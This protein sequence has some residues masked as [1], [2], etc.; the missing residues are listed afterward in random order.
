MPQTAP[1]LALAVAMVRTVASWQAFL[2]TVLNVTWAA[3]MPLHGQFHL[4]DM[5]SIGDSLPLQ[6]AGGMLAT[7][8]R[9]KY[10][11]IL[12]GAIAGSAPIWSYLGEVRLT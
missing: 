7:W 12:D 8:M 11:H 10:P 9:I 6:C 5:P 2:W 3:V 1:S 4:K